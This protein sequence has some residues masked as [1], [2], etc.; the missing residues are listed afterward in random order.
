MEAPANPRVSRWSDAPS[1]QPSA[2]VTQDTDNGHG[3]GA[4][5]ADQGFGASSAYSGERSYG[6]FAPGSARGSELRKPP[7][8]WEEMVKQ[9]GSAFNMGPSGRSAEPPRRSNKPCRFYLEGHCPYGDRCTFS[10]GNEDLQRESAPAMD[11]SPAG[12]APGRSNYKTRLCT[13]WEK[14]E[15]C[16]YGDKCHFAHGQAELRAYSGGGGPN[17]GVTGSNYSTGGTGPSTYVDPGMMNAPP[18]AAPYGAPPNYG[19]DGSNGYSTNYT[20]WN[21]ENKWDGSNPAVPAPVPAPVLPMQGYSQTNQTTPWMPN[22]SAD[23]SYPKLDNNAAPYYNPDLS[24]QQQLPPQQ[25]FPLQQQQQQGVPYYGSGAPSYQDPSQ[26]VNPPYSQ[27]AG[28]NGDGSAYYSSN[29]TTQQ[30]GYTEAVYGRITE[31][32]LLSVS[33]ELSRLLTCQIANSFSGQSVG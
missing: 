20:Y 25:H 18:M 21:T 26:G 2:T 3:F 28:Q 33:L 15:L 30:Q 5:S 12:N 1:G 13:R 9:G 29:Y 22:Y 7:P 8:G 19:N 10:H 4:S 24:Q 17:T 14:G 27:D 16:I 11:P 31:F 23:G 6:S 32:Y